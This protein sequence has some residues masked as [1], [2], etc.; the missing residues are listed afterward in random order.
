MKVIKLKMLRVKQIPEIL[1]QELSD[2]ILGV[3]LMTTEGSLLSAK[4][5]EGSLISEALLG[6]VASSIW[7]NNS[8][9]TSQILE[10]KS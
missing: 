1:Q 10:E 9:G 3:C 6:A 2:G 7:A 4:V 8:N 5:A